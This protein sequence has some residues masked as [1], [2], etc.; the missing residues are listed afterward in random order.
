MA[1]EV[2]G[3]FGERPHSNAGSPQAHRQ[4]QLLSFTVKDDL[5]SLLPEAGYK[6]GKGQAVEVALLK[7]KPNLKYDDIFV[8]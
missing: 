8:I 4:L 7:N 5:N 2:T 6:P 3:L 1:C